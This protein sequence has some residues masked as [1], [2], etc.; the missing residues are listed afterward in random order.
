MTWDV[1]ECVCVTA[2]C[3][4]NGCR[5]SVLR[6]SC[7]SSR[8]SPCAAPPPPPPPCSCCWWRGPGGSCRASRCPPSWPR[9]CTFLSQTWGSLETRDHST[10]TC[11]WCWWWVTGL[12]QSHLPGHVIHVVRQLPQSPPDPLLGDPLLGELETASPA[13][14]NSQHPPDGVR[15]SPEH[16]ANNDHHDEGNDNY[17]S[18]TVHQMMYF[19]WHVIVTVIMIFMITKFCFVLR[20]IAVSHK[21]LTINFYRKLFI[22][23]MVLHINFLIKSYPTHS[24]ILIEFWLHWLTQSSERNHYLKIFRNI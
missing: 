23:L 10:W 17:E 8:P 9:Y 15:D 18:V 2:A 24:H 13:N 19:S 20:E 21:N 22:V 3:P 1:W 14:V 5:W 11:R 7:C 12:T 4:G 16:Q 6:G